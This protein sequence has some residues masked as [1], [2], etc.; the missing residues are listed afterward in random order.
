MSSPLETLAS[1]ILPVF[2]VVGIG[3]LAAISRLITETGF[4]QLMK[5]ATN[6]AIPC[7]LFGAIS[8]I[9]ISASFGIAMLGTFYGAASLGFVAGM[10]GARFLFAR[11]WEDAVAIGFCTLYGNV[12]LVGLPIT[13]RAYGGVALDSVYAILALHAPLCY[14]LG[15]L[16]MEV[17]RNSG[18]GVLRTV[19]QVALGML[20][21]PIML[22]IYAGFFA[23]LTGLL[24]PDALDQAVDLLAQA[25]LPAALFALGG[26]L[27]RYRPEGDLRLIGYIALLSL[28]VQPALTLGFATLLRLELAQLQ[29][30]V[31]AASVAPGVNAYLFANMYGRARRV[32]ASS[33]LLA[34][35]GSI[36]TIWLWLQIL[37]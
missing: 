26:I 30:A 3:Y 25:A 17:V 16:V 32:A 14:L 19:G 37:P 34:T 7:L 21:N 9:D 29:G 6:F 5:F 15:I 8:T 10:L 11:D 33:V 27:Y 22:G 20:R 13:E 1:V 2:V 28:F 31:L 4:D 12:M 18:R 24:L 36:V 35:A 23:N